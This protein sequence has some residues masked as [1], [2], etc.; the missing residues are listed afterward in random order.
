MGATSSWAERWAHTAKL[1]WSDVVGPK[2]STILER[3][4]ARAAGLRVD[5][6][7]NDYLEAI[8]LDMWGRKSS[9]RRRGA[10][11]P[12][13]VKKWLARR[14]DDAAKRMEARAA[15]VAGADPPAAELPA[16]TARSRFITSSSSYM[17]QSVLEPADAMLLDRFKRRKI[18]AMPFQAGNKK[19][20]WEDLTR[21]DENLRATMHGRKWLLA[22]MAGHVAPARPKRS[23]S[24]SSSSTSSSTSS[25]SSSSS[26]P[27]PSRAPGA[28]P[29]R[30]IATMPAADAGAAPSPVAGEASASPVAGEAS[31]SPAAGDAAPHKKKIL[32]VCSGSGILHGRIDGGGGGDQHYLCAPFRKSAS[33]LKMGESMSLAAARAMAGAEW[34]GVCASILE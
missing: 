3:F 2:P 8:A 12:G 20:W 27:P 33:A 19:Q 31:A 22:P 6:T 7:D 13:G 24:S 10:R 29:A 21:E 5:G 11:A 15:P 23:V 34:H 30:D 14:A 25:P 32:W 1:Q 16:P 18:A 4:A 28:R 26:S 9:N 17:D